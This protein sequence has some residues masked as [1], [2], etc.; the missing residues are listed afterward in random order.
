MKIGTHVSIQA[1]LTAIQAINVASLANVSWI[2][3]KYSAIIALAVTT[4]QAGIG[5]YNHYFAPN[6]Q[7]VGGTK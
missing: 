6:G 7:S 2:P 4:A 3:M 1:I 5:I